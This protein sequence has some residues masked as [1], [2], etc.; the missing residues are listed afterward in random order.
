MIGRRRTGRR[1]S[2]PVTDRRRS[3][4]KGETRWWD[5]VD[6]AMVEEPLLRLGDLGRGWNDISM[7]NNTELLDP[8][9]PG[10]AADQLRSARDLRVLTALDEGQA[11]RRRDGGVLLVARV[12]AFGDA[13]SSAHRQTWQRDGAR[14]LEDTWRERWRDREVVPGWIEAKL[15]DG[16]GTDTGDEDHIDWY[17]VEDHTGVTGEVVVYQHLTV[18]AGRLLVVL[19]LRHDLGLDVDDVVAAAARTVGDRAAARQA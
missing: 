4:P 5:P 8:Y 1:P 10:E 14:C 16:A 11:W 18:W 12:E 19:T 17:R 3:G 7:R 15:L 13:D 9:G 6:Q 2:G